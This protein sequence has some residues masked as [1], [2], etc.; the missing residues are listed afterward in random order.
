MSLNL[1]KGQRTSISA[2]LVCEMVSRKTVWYLFNIPTAWFL[3]LVRD[4]RILLSEACRFVSW[5]CCE[6]LAASVA[7]LYSGRLFLSRINFDSSACVLR[8]AAPSG[9]VL[10]QFVTTISLLPGSWGSFGMPEFCLV[11][12]PWVGMQDGLCGVCRRVTTVADCFSAELISTRPH[13]FYEQRFHLAA[14]YY[15]LSATYYYDLLACIC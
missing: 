10:Q 5:F 1:I 6:K 9:G 2:Y 8:A 4:S 13:V 11:E 15:N 3:G 12:Q 7:G 14:C